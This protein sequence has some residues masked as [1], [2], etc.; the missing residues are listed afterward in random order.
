[1]QTDK[2]RSYVGF[3]VRAN[4]VKIGVD[5]ILSAK[6]LP[7]VVLYDERLASN[8]KK[9]LLARCAGTKTFVIDV[10]AVFPGKNCLAIGVCEKNLAGAICKEMEENS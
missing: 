10:E 8:S 1:M 4:K 2:I 5:N 7:Y 6:Y 3:A 9:K